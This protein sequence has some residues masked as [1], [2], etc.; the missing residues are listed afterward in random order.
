LSKSLAGAGIYSSTLS[1]N[2]KIEFLPIA[3]SL[4]S[5][6]AKAEPFT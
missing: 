2:S 4:S 1:I 6:A 5:T 3:S